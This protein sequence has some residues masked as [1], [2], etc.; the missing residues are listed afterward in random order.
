MNVL[1]TPPPPD[2]G[3]P[4]VLAPPRPWV[5]F[6]PLSPTLLP[7]GKPFIYPWKTPWRMWPRST[8][9]LAAELPNTRMQSE[10][11]GVYHRLQGSVQGCQDNAPLPAS[12]RATLDAPIFLH[13]ALRPGLRM[14]V[15]DLRAAE[16]QDFVL[17]CGSFPTT[18]IATSVTSGGR[19]RC[20]LYRACR[21]R[22]RIGILI[23]QDSPTTYRSFFWAR[24]PAGC[25]LASAAS[26]V[27][28]NR[29]LTLN[30]GSFKVIQKTDSL[31]SSTLTKLSF[32]PW[33]RLKFIFLTLSLINLT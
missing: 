29:K 6:P 13:P 19:V 26:C 21:C 10:S 14:E 17:V 2:S 5:S 12:W 4:K 25:C 8:H 32:S 16:P 30:K 20:T 7:W 27:F 11:K 31:P 22:C 1:P 18:V 3:L 33:Y 9:Q 24:R 23:R 15:S 28:Q